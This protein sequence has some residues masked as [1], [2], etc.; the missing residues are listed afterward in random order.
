MIA[1]FCLYVASCLPRNEQQ[2]KLT[3]QTTWD[4]FDK[5]D[6]V[7]EAIIENVPIKQA[8]TLTPAPTLFISYANNDSESRPPLSPSQTHA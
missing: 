3:P 1:L 4:G 2:R 7:V 8:V 5:V 6:L